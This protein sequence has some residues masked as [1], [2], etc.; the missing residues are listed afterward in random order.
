MSPPSSASCRRAHLGWSCSFRWT[1]RSAQSGAA[2]WPRRRFR[3]SRATRSSTSRSHQTT[4]SSPPLANLAGRMKLRELSAALSPTEVVGDDSVEIADLA[5]AAGGVRP[6]A[7]FF[8]VPGARTDGHDFAAAAV[9]RGAAALA[10]EHRLPIDVPQA[11]VDDTRAA[12]PAAAAAFFGHPTRELEVAGVTGTAGK[13]TTTYLLYAI[14]DAAGRRPGLM[15]TVESRIGGERKPAVRTTPE[16][17]DLQRAF[18]AM[19]DVGDRSV[20]LEATSHGSELGRLAGIRFAALAFTTLSEEPL[21]FHETME[22]YFAAKRRLF[23]GSEPPRAAVNVGDPF[24]RDLADELRA[25]GRAPVL[26]FG[27]ADDAEIKA[28]RLDGGRLRAGGIDLETRL[29]GRFNVENILAAVAVALLLDVPDEAIAEGIAGVEGVPGRFE[30]V[31]EG[32]PFMV[33]VASS[34][35]P[36]ALE[37]VLRAARDLATGRVLCVFGCGGDRDRAK[38]P[39]MGRIAADLA[40]S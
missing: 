35:K 39:L 32:Q 8:C 28:E 23:V 16:T 18:R 12:M 9:E 2:W 25:L 34:H 17:I 1:S 20:A 13:T 38:R 30:T 29:R 33:V 40:D 14:L 19:L 36:G 7:L 15:G 22:R 5:Y 27:F 10:V 24:G 21:D 4:F 31:D 3:R 37:N 6:G 11:V 26:T